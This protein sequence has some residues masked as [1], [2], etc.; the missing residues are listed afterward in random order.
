MTRRLRRLA[1][2]IALGVGVLAC[3]GAAA[4]PAPE[5][6][7]AA[8][9]LRGAWTEAEAERAAERLAVVAE[10]YPVIG[11]HAALLAGGRLLAAE[12]P[13]EAAAAARAGL[14][15]HPDSPLLARLHQLEA[16]ARAAAGDD[17]GAR[18]AWEQ[19]L[20]A[21]PSP[22]LRA[23]LGLE[24]AASLER[25]G[26][27]R[28]AVPHYRAVWIAAGEREP[29]ERAGERLVALE[30]ELGEPLRDARGRVARADALFDARRSEDALGE[31]ETALTDVTLPVRTTRHA[32]RR[33]ADCLFRLRR[34]PEA[35]EAYGEL[36]EVDPVA[37]VE[38]ARSVARA[39]DVDAAVV[40]LEAIAGEAGHP[41]RRR[42]R[43][44]AA[45]LLEDDHPERARA[46][47][48]ELA[49]SAGRTGM[50]RD[51]R[52]KLGWEAYRAGRD[53]EAKRQLGRLA[54]EQPDPIGALRARYWLAR[55]AE[56]SDAEL[57]QRQLAEIAGSYP[58]SYYG[59]RARGRLSAVGVPKAAG[60]ALPVEASRFKPRALARPRI[61]LEAGLLDEARW[62]LDRLAPMARMSSDRLA[63][64][65][66]YRDVGAFHEAQ[67]L[68][69]GP[70]AET[71]ARGPAA[72]AERRPWRLAWP[73]AYDE[74]VRRESAA[75]E[76][77][78]S[79]E[80]VYAIMREESGYR[81]KVVSTVGARGLL[82][83]M[84]DTGER[85]ARDLGFALA[86]DD[87]FRPGVNIRLG[88]AYLDQLGLRF[89]GRAS[90]A[91]GSYNAGPEAVDRWLARDGG[92]DD[93]VWV[94]AIP[95]DQT[96]GYVKRVL[97]SMLAYEVLY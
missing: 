72:S 59:W 7:A 46:Q 33:R 84:P 70:Y 81:P 97:R 71:L 2:G 74:L 19:A 18:A 87:L 17:A 60:D 82:Q 11:D 22:A 41:Q 14:R 45:L 94:E 93:D 8:E 61:L 50:G 43:Y 58:L 54:E 65:S 62:E 42:A 90:A 5:V 79:P 67:S 89:A 34:Y 36:A 53:E 63:F 56:R 64:A 9:A 77:R 57:G 44:L 69:V 88:T 39:G 23:S 92:V 32:R 20:A 25:A 52:W 29:S 78:V 3:E 28:E 95:Y 24:L 91:I 16:E 86:P 85:V 68:I 83:I 30:E 76:G 73:R 1:A 21:E 6:T 35:A 40:Q 26:L 12:K 75:S 38:R 96:R 10:R 27:A 31:Y 66:L 13:A 47:F 15:Q 51:A 80:L 55:L 37:R 4:P 49:R 48:A